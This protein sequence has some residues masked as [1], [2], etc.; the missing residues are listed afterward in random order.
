MIIILLILGLFLGSFLG[1]LVDRIPR[2]E[3]VI[4]GRSHCE[5][6]KKELAWYD[7]VPVLSF[8]FLKGKCRYCKTRL[9]FFYPVIEITTAVIFGLVY[10]FFGALGFAYLLYFLFVSGIFIVV[11]FTDLKYGIIPDKILYPGIIVSVLFALIFQKSEFLNHL[12]SGILSFAFFVAVS[13]IFFVLTKKE[14]MGGGDIKLA[15]FLGLVL[16]FPNILVCLYIAFLTGSAI[17]II[18][19]IWKKKSFQKD[20]LPFGPFMVTGA[21]ISLFW[22]NQIFSYFLKILGI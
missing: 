3:N 22:G 9:P 14:S 4:N 8:V 5:H 18:L 11:F 10:L 7:L 20:T 2:K 1:V 15:L 13:Y 16:G 17:S 19:I 6:C 21:A 12:A